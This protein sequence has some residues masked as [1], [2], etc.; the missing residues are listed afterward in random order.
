MDQ[1]I[2]VFA[3]IIKL[4]W[5]LSGLVL[6][7]VIYNYIGWFLVCLF[8]TKMLQSGIKNIRDLLVFFFF[9]SFL[10]YLTSSL[11]IDLWVFI[12]SLVMKINQSIVINIGPAHPSCHGV[13]RMIAI[14]NGELIQYLTVEIGLLHRG[15]EK[16]ME[17]NNYINS[18]G[19]MDRL[20]YVSTISQE[21][22]FVNVMERIINCYEVIYSAV[23]RTLFLEFFRILN[24]LLAITTSIIDLGLFTTMLLMFE[25]RE[26]LLNFVES[27]SGTRFH[28]MFVLLGRIRYDITL[29]LI[30]SLIEWLLNFIRK[31]KELHNIT[32]ENSIFRSRLY[33]IGIVPSDFC[34]YFGISGVVARAAGIMLDARIIGYEYYNAI[35][36][37]LFFSVLS[38]CWS[39]FFM[40]ILETLQSSDIIYT[41]L[42]IIL[43]SFIINNSFG[44]SSMEEVITNFCYPSLMLDNFPSTSL[45]RDKYNSNNWYGLY[46][47]CKVSIESSKGIYSIFVNSMLPHSSSR[48]FT[49]NIVANDFLM[50]TQLGRLTKSMN[51]ADLIALLGSLDFVLG[52]VDL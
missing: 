27:L 28:A 19:Y 14:L 3:L 45:R 50:I 10:S 2:K 33:E 9:L 4:A 12:T 36:F 30:N 23:L 32:S 40:R 17:T 38:D 29:K 49:V 46:S 21:I 37:A 44:N 15:T 7:G 6:N 34:L 8:L 20:D 26:K 41:I 13:L 51:L 24:H 5:A 35:D 31:L 16:L 22:L 18:I 39:R 52:A 1:C 25:E 48:A 47:A 42:Y 11:R 43:N